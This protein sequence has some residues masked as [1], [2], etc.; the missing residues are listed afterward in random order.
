MK[1]PNKKYFEKV[2]NESD[3]Q[4]QFNYLFQ[5]NYGRIYYSYNTDGLFRVDGHLILCE[6]KE[7]LYDFNQD[8]YYKVL[9]QIL[10]YLKSFENNCEHLPSKCFVSNS[11]QFFVIKSDV[12][13][14]YL[15]KNYDW[16]EAASSLSNETLKKVKQDFSGDSQ[17]I[18]RKYSVQPSSFYEEDA[19]SFNILEKLL[20]E[21]NIISSD[22]NSIFFGC[23]SVEDYKIL[24]ENDCKNKNYGLARKREKFLARDDF[25]LGKW[26]NSG[27]SQSVHTP[28]WFCQ[29]MIDKII[30]T[31]GGIENIK[32]KT[33]SIY[34]AE[35]LD[36]LCFLDILSENK[37]YLITDNKRKIEFT[38]SAYENVEC[39]YVDNYS[40]WKPRM[41]FD[42][43]IG[44][45][46]YNADRQEANGN[47]IWDGFVEKS[48]K[49][50]AENGYLCYVHPAGWRKP[51]HTLWNKLTSLQIYYLEI[52]NN[53]D[54]QKV[55][56]VSTRYDWYILQNTPAKIKTIVIDELKNKHD[57][58]LSKEKFLPNYL[59]EEISSLISTQNDCCE[60][61]HGGMY[62]TNTPYISRE[63]TDTHNLPIF[64][65]L[66]KNNK[67]RL[68]WS[69]EN[70]GHF[71]VPKVICSGERYL[72]TLN[73]FAGK[74][75][76]NSHSFGIPISSYEEGEEVMRALNSE[77]F[78]EI[79]KA[80]KWSNYQT[81]VKFIKS[82]KKDFWK[83]F[84]K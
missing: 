31:M 49:L 41:K 20:K 30:E 54:G 56:G 28:F 26:G 84:I 22:P 32:G 38:K 14:P 1:L 19:D 21:D 18:V 5:L 40:I 46:P 71:G 76:I 55:F 13:A 35:Y 69:S 67:L 7:P 15:S 61:I 47:I 81:E 52:H 78:K 6:Y 59:I 53:D 62:S 8:N 24:L 79:M 16:S 3:V 65:S 37:V 11:I 29:M 12:L 27:S 51:G 36:Y 9:A 60:I 82:L 68:V 64:L 66:D 72:Y 4:F 17:L 43:I 80:T 57:I 63:K 33:I 10:W 23:E 45:P 83:Q 77:K 44:N 39:I 74:Y 58:D 75:G 42:I 25:V 70:K 2:V 50:L 73:D 48:L 34:N